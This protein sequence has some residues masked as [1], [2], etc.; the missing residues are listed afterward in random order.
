MAF[1]MLNE[2]FNVQKASQEERGYTFP[3]EGEDAAK[4]IKTQSLHCIDELCEMLHEVKGYKEWKVYD[5]KDELTNRVAKNKATEELIDAFHF[6]VNIALGL[7]ISPEEFYQV[8]MNKQQINK[9]R[10]ADTV[11]YKKDVEE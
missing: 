4:Y 9:Q 10:L 8:Y 7:G 5:Y 1:D 3:M 6:F 11:N 2:I